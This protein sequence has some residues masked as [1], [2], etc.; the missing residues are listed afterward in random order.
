VAAG[1]VMAQPFVEPC[2]RGIIDAERCPRELGR[3]ISLQRRRIVL[4]ACV[5]PRGSL[6]EV[7]SGILITRQ[8]DHK[9]GRASLIVGPIA[10][11]PF[12]LVFLIQRRVSLRR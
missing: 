12:Q 3:E 5:P 2:S 10:P 4:T 6:S 7:R 1:Y 9:L 8:V 11:L